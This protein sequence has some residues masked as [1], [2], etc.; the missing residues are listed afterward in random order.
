MIY[1]IV[2]VLFFLCGLVATQST[3]QRIKGNGLLF[4]MS[5]V[6]FLIAGLLV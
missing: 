6:L 1:I 3:N 5:A 4:L 2:A